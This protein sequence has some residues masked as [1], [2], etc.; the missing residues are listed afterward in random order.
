MPTKAQQRPGYVYKTVAIPEAAYAQVEAYAKR[1]RLPVTEA[2][3]LIVGATGPHLAAAAAAGPPGSPDV[4]VEQLRAAQ[5]M[6][7]KDFGGKHNWASGGK[8]SAG[9]GA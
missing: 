8:E 6:R 2:I 7:R 5:R 3:G 9:A 4:L 1:F